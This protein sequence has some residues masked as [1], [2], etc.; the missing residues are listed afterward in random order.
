M[1]PKI[2]LARASDAWHQALGGYPSTHILK[3][4]IEKKPTVIFDEE[5]GARLARRLDLAR[6]DTRIEEFDGLP[7]LVI[8]RFDRAHGLRVH[9]EDFNQAL[10]AAGNQKYQEIGGVVSLRRV[11]DTLY[12]YATTSDIDKLAQMTTL[13]VA[14]GNLDMHTKNLGL[15]HPASGDVTLA[16]AYD[17]VPMAHHRDSDGKMALA[18]NKKYQHSEVTRADLVA[19]MQ[20]WGA[21]RPEQLVQSTLERLFEIAEGEQPLDGAYPLLRDDVLRFTRNLIEGRAVGGG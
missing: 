11:A 5:Y 21:R 12:R 15:L 3:P 4:Q 18:V 10:G 20:T 8:E 14:V 17:V 6:F 7:A 19:E 9:Q 13:A 16:P 2:V 1:Q